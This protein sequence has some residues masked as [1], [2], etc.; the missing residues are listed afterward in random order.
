MNIKKLD[1]IRE[2]ESKNSKF[3]GNGYL[4]NTSYSNCPLLLSK[5]TIYILNNLKHQHFI[6]LHNW[7][8]GEPFCWSYLRSFTLLQSSDSLAGGGGP[9]WHPSQVSQ[10]APGCCWGTQLSSKWPSIL[11]WGKLGFLIIWYH[12]RV[13]R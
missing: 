1:L 8:L 9:R 5:Q 12:L 11:Q 13:P 4:I 6:I 7:G 10:L 2:S 3:S